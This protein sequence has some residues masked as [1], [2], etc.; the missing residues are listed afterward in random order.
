MFGIVKS[1]KT[2]TTNHNHTHDPHNH[3]DYN[4]GTSRILRRHTTPCVGMRAEQGRQRGIRKPKKLNRLA[5]GRLQG[6][7][8]CNGGR[9]V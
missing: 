9:G 1:R 3:N 4:Y 2:T 5:P 6:E 7:V 8:L